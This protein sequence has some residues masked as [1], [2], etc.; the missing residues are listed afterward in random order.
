VRV[1][2]GLNMKPSLIHPR[3]VTI[4]V[5]TIGERDAFGDPNNVSE[6]AVTLKGQV[7]YSKYDRMSLPGGGDDPQGDGHVI[8]K[9]ETWDSS[10]GKK[11]DDL[12]LS[13][14]DSRLVILEIQPCGHYGGTA[15]LRKVIFSR[16]RATS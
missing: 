13:P 10:G 3:D 7:H 15:H 1:E 6:T 9:A 11:G 12:V 14:S 2:E 8:F 4:H 5:K 16:R